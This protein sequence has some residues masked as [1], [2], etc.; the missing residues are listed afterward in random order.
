VQT[1]K[2]KASYRDGVLTIMMPKAEEL[3]PKAI[4]IEAV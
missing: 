4:K 1:D 2:V 3:K